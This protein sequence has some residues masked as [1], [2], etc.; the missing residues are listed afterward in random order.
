[1]KPYRQDK[2]A[3]APPRPY[4][5]IARDVQNAMRDRRG[6]RDGHTLGVEH[7]RNRRAMAMCLIFVWQIRMSAHNHEAGEDIL[8]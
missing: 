3:F 1:V 2:D 4:Q 6:C 5:H 8:R 7:A